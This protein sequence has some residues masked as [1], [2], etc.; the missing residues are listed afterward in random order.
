[1]KELNDVPGARKSAEP[2]IQ[3]LPELVRN[4]IAAGEVIERPASV[5]KELLE[6]ALDA[7][8]RNIRVDLEEGGAK[9]VRVIDDGCGMGAEDL[10]RSFLAHA[11]SK[12][13]DPEDLLHIATLGFRGEALASIGSVARC[14]ISTRLLG[15]SVGRRIEN[16][17]GRLGEVLEA[18]GTEGTTIEVRDLFY[19]T[20]ARRRFL[21]RP[22]TELGRCL[23]ILQRLALAHDGVGFVATHDGKRIFDVEAEMDLRGRVRRTFGAELADA[24]EPV[25]A[26]DGDTVLQG[27]VAPPRFSRTDTSRQMWF[28]NGRPV[29]DK[30]LVRVLKE[31]FRGFLVENRQPVAFLRLA[32]DPQGVDVNVHP[33][34]TEVRFRDQRRLFGFLVN[35]LREAVRLTDMSTP[36]DRMLDGL[37]RRGAW[38]PEDAPGQ[39]VLPDPGSA[40]RRGP[41][42]EGDWVLREV[43]GGGANRSDATHGGSFVDSLDGGSP[44]GSDPSGSAPIGGGYA[45]GSTIGGSASGS[46]EEG[47]EAWAPRDELEGPFLQ[48]AKT[49][50]VRALP[51]GFE[52]VDQHALHERLTFEELR[53][54]LRAGS[55]EVQRLLVPE[56]VEVSRAQVALLDEHR[57]SAERVGIVLEPFGP[58]TVA[59]HGLPARLRHPDPEGVVRDLL[60]VVERT[61][62]APD[63][64]DVIEEVLHRTA[65]RSSVMAGDR[66]GDDEI[67]SLLGR[68]AALETDQTCPHARPTRVKFSLA[69][70]EKAF[71][72]R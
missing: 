51:D 46:I 16:E 5:L 21:K 44:P 38:R 34:K 66:L 52:I 30:V 7:G 70:L 58:T 11:T 54:E 37:A 59:L 72:R 31:G 45:S 28:L 49:Y 18:G 39:G 65:C 55:V 4:Q 50:L 57:E 10:R 32:M 2:R 69:D 64:E 60:E 8:A 6:N 42:V 47:R 20:P 41:R 22:A 15:E 63:A 53:R 62:Q 3:A 19:N 14:R 9:L 1:M 27:F 48:V 23:D 26:R 67:R 56:L 29:R 43:P 61:G 33:A 17:G 25:E 68:A 40:G 36:G 24:L 71:H 35:A 12:L 13:R